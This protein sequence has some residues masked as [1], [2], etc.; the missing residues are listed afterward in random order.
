MNVH[1][2]QSS[3]IEE[4]KDLEFC[5]VTSTSLHVVVTYLRLIL[6][7]TS[8]LFLIHLFS[9]GLVI[10]TLVSFSQIEFSLSHHITVFFPC[11]C[12]W[13]IACRGVVS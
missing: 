7:Y 11:L 5:E 2:E 1:I 10:I 12:F 4:S 8:I 3:W 9:L 6:L 13:D